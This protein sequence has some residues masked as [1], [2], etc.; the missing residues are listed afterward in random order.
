[1]KLKVAIL[2]MGRW[3]MNLHQSILN[4]DRIEVTHACTR[5]PDKVRTYCEQH[6]IDLT[7]SYETILANSDIDAVLIATPHTQ[8]YEQ[9]MQAANSGK[10]VF[11]EKPFTLSGTEA[12]RALEKLAERNLKVG[13]GHNRRFA[14]NTM[15]LKSMLDKKELGEIIYVDGMFSAQMSGSKD[16]WRD[17]RRESPAGGMTSLGIHVV[18]MFTH[19]CGEMSR[20][21]AR[22]QRRVSNCAFDDAT[23]VDLTFKAGFFGVLT[24]LTASP[25]QWCIRVYGTRGK[26]E[27]HEQ[28]VLKLL[29]DGES[30]QDPDKPIPKTSRAN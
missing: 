26:A 15:A 18:D 9:I 13:I 19:L 17:S 27:L 25:M 4:S 24:T 1:M 8:H 21:S 30:E 3:G 7:D 11:S 2:G 14:P 20:V 23:I 28:D 5:S 29:K 10:H 16:Q 22:S 12:K 6:Q